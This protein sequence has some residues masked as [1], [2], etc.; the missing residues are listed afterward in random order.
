MVEFNAKPN[1]AFFTGKALFIA[2]FYFFCF[3]CSGVV[4]GEVIFQDNFDSQ[5]NWTIAQ[6]TSATEICVSD[7]DV[8]E[9]WTGYFNGF[10]YC[11]GGP[12]YNTIYLNEYIGYPPET[13]ERG[14]GGEGKALTFWDESCCN[15]FEDS[16][17]MLAVDLGQEYQ[18]LYVRFFIKF[19]NTASDPATP[20]QLGYLSS[21]T[22][23]HKFLHVQH[24]LDGNPWSY[25]STNEGNQPLFVANFKHWN[26]RYEATGTGRC[27]CGD[28]GGE[29][30]YYC[31]GSPSGSGGFADQVGTYDWYD[32][33]AIGD[34][35]WH[36]VEWRL[37]MNTYDEVNGTFRADGI[38]Q[39]WHDGVLQ[40]ESTTVPWNQNG[41]ATDPI[42]GFR[43]VSIGGNNQ[44]RW[45]TDCSGT[46]CEQWY[47]VDDVVLSTQ[48]IGPDYSI[49]DPNTT[50]DIN[51]DGSVDSGDIDACISH[52]LGIQDWGAKADVNGDGSVNALDIQGIVKIILEQ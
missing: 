47:A 49:S 17:G 4:H 44:N 46:G 11:D 7:C 32:E 39:F 34:G 8:P 45:T 24:Y 3:F 2:G 28:G 48:Y 27:F 30:C 23:S 29:D 51:S 50:N 33:G 38:I 16:D 18:E 42:R 6:P 37:K 40:L 15:F 5:D 31:D 14:R 13:T 10:S 35:E 26:D 36:C 21:G 12:G 22:G 43:F 1:R 19:G 41:A 20:W 9:G 25:F 52:I